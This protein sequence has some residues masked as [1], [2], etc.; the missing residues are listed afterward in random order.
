MSNSI[1]NL[2]KIS[3]GGPYTSNIELANDLSD[4]FGEVTF[5]DDFFIGGYKEDSTD[6]VL[7]SPDV[8]YNP[9]DSITVTVLFGGTNGSF[10]SRCFQ[11]YLNF[12]IIAGGP[13]PGSV[14]ITPITSPVADTLQWTIVDNIAE[15]VIFSLT[16]ITA[17]NDYYVLNIGDVITNNPFSLE[18]T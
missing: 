1:I 5:P 12:S 10:A 13:P 6:I 3:K 14:V 2:G 9:N 4:T 16:S 7:S 15:V 8:V 17:W 18:W 11:N